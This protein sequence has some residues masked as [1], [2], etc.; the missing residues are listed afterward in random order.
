VPYIVSKDFFTDDS[1]PQITWD[2]GGKNTKEFSQ[3]LF[4]GVCGL[5]SGAEVV[6]TD[7]ADPKGIIVVG[8]M[9]SGQSAYQIKD[10]ESQVLK[11]LYDNYKVGRDYEG[12]PEYL[13]YDDFVSAKNNHFIFKDGL[14]DWQIYINSDYAPLA[15]CGKPIIYLYPTKPTQVSVEVGAKM[16]KTEPEYNSG[17]N[18]MAY[19]SGQINNNGTSYPYLFW[20]GQG[21]GIYPE[22]SDYGIVVKSTDAIST[23][24]AQLK[25]MGLTNKEINDF[26]E[27]WGDKLPTKPYVRLTWF[28]TNE[29]DILA[30]LKVEPKPDTRIRVFMEFE[31][32]DNYKN[33]K[34]QKFNAPKRN[35]FTLVEWG[36]LLL[37]ENR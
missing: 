7:R 11:I 18:V 30:P 13:S 36:G 15:E 9:N 14:G 2:D 12:A 31:G 5:G 4:G 8:K 6:F 19:P 21:N 1:V 24:K 34:P 29:M 22:M 20:E 17:W 10:K 23:I 28:G 3:H 26:V 37:G 27:F 32:L 25:E 35:G 33:L 16:T